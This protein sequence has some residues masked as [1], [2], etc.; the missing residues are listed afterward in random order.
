MEF[1]LK[2]AIFM[3]ASHSPRGQRDHGHKPQRGHPQ[4]QPKRAWLISHDDAPP[5]AFDDYAAQRSVGL[6]DPGGPAV[7]RRRPAGEIR[8]SENQHPA[9]VHVWLEF[10]ERWAPPSVHCGLTRSG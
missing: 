2:V 6:P 3:T 9:A 4:S 1:T 7:D 8:V 10:D 5:P